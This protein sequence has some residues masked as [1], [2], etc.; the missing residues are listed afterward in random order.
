VQLTN[1][2]TTKNDKTIWN[3]IFLVIKPT[4][5][6]DFSN[7]FWN[8]TLH[9]SDSP[10]VHHQELFTV[11]SAMVYVIPVCRQLSSRIRMELPDHDGTAFPS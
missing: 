7:L 1:N 9:V 3:I 11:N 6:T 8:E 10:S 4:R 2:D 5:R